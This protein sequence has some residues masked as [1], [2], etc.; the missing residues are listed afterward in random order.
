MPF[1]FGHSQQDA[2]HLHRQLRG[3]VDQEVK[4]HAGFDPVEQPAR[5]GTQ[6]ILDAPD[7]AR[8]QPGADQPADLGVPRVIHHVEHLAGDRQVLQQGAAVGPFATG[9]R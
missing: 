1:G 3:H 4:A 6:V 2:D 7:H 5:A 8:G 9:H